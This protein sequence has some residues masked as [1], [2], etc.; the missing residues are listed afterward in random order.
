MNCLT[1]AIRSL[2]IATLYDL[3][4][5]QRQRQAMIAALRGQL[6]T[7]RTAARRPPIC[8]LSGVHAGQGCPPASLREATLH[9]AERRSLGMHCEAGF[10]RHAAGC[11]WWSGRQGSGL[12]RSGAVITMG[13]AVLIE[14]AFINSTLTTPSSVAASLGMGFP[15]LVAVTLPSPM[16]HFSLPIREVPH[17]KTGTI[18]C[19]SLTLPDR[20]CSDI[21]AFRDIFLL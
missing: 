15:P 8:L 4:D 19:A 1:I 11:R 10:L 7:P 6:V 17:K 12:T 21:A 3:T 18:E 2:G 5:G 14:L 13:A 16:S 20:L 9:D